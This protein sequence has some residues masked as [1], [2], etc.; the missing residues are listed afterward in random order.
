MKNCSVCGREIFTELEEFGDPREPVCETCWLGG[1]IQPE[2]E[3]REG[4]VHE[5]ELFRTGYSYDH[6]N[7]KVYRYEKSKCK[8]CGK[9]KIFQQFD[10]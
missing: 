8:K 1:V 9:V 4:C 5:F 7:G 3:S 6:D 10:L 2:A